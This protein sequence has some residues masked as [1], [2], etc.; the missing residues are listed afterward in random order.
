[1][2]LAGIAF[3]FTAPAILAGALY[4]QCQVQKLLAA[5]AHQFD[6]FGQA[7]AISGDWAVVGAPS[8]STIADVSGA[9]YV[10]QRVGTIWTQTQK[11]KA[12]DAAFGDNFGSSV[13]IEG[14]TFVVGAPGATI[15]G[16][17]GA[18]AAYVF[19][20]SGSVWSE[21]FKIVL[22]PAM[23]QPRLGL[24]AVIDQGR[25]LI[26][27]RS[28]PV[29]G[30]ESGAA[31]LFERSGSSWTETAMLYGDTTVP[32]DG[33][34]MSISLYG[35]RAVLGYPV[36]SLPGAFAAGSAFVFENPGTGWI[37]TQ[38]LV[39]SDAVANDY[40]G[41]AVALTAS[42]D[43]AVSAP[44]HTHAGI[45]AAGVLYVFQYSNRSWHQSQETWPDDSGQVD[46]FGS[47]MASD[48]IHLIVGSNYGFAGSAYDYRISGGFGIQAGKLLASDS[49]N[50]D[51]FAIGLAVSGDTAL[52]GAE[53]GDDACSGNP[54]C[55]SG[56]A[57]IF[58]L[59]PTATQYGHCPSAAPCNNTDKHGGCRNSTGQGAILAACGSGSA[60]VDDIQMEVTHCPPNKLTLL[61]MGGGQVH[62]PFADGYRDVSGGGVG[63]FRFGGL[64]ADSTGR[65]MRG[66]GLVAQS[67]TFHGANGHIQAGQTWNFQVWY[68][69]TT[70][71]CG[72]GTNYSNGVQVAFTP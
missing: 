67:Q 56:K 23:D 3:V 10:F 40:F 22:P 39:A 49:A 70:G 37:Q 71:P 48:G 59:A 30:S 7:V 16:V 72:Q 15:Q 36:H 65:A 18:G 24:P 5:D 4:G 11:I 34:G 68:R 63:V 42:G 47:F 50:A 21:S 1:M 45:G 35:E 58:A 55:D 44:P 31:H 25:I 43:L 17:T 12:S 52:I 19:E 54:N 27:A 8:E 61:Y 53:G 62:V 20:L 66:P 60:S 41:T 57:Y 32:F 69:D 26:G 29:H 6:Q 64:A 38:R 46:Q 28:E 51:G 13:A 14:A 33:A 9:V 2:K